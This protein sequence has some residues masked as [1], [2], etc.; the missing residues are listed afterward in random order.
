[1][2]L[3]SLFTSFIKIRNCSDQNIW[4]MLFGSSG[5]MLTVAAAVPHRRQVIM[6]SCKKTL[7][8]LHR[9]L[10][11]FSPYKPSLHV[12]SRLSTTGIKIKKLKMK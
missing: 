2:D 4:L 5:R 6:Y 12:F 8:Q 3:L 11:L 1:L 9:E 7:K 10:R